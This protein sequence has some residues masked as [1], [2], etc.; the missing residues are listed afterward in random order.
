MSQTVNSSGFGNQT[1]SKYK[2]RSNY[3]NQMRGG[4]YHRELP[5]ASLLRKTNA[6]VDMTQT[7]STEDTEVNKVAPPDPQKL[8]IVAI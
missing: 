4:K 3:S 8:Y 1:A 7:E 5:G 2:Q 6:N